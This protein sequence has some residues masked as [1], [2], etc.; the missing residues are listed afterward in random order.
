VAKSNSGGVGL[1]FQATL[2]RANNNLGWVI[3]RLPA[4]ATAKLGGRGQIRVIGNISGSGATSTPFIFRTTLF[5]DGKGGH[6]LLV[7]RT[8]QKGASV[9]L[10]HVAEIHLQ[11]DIEQRKVEMPRE[12]GLALKQD[13][14]LMRWFNE[15]LS[16]SQRQ[17]TARFISQPRSAAARKRRAERLAERFM[18]TMEAEHDL[19][20][21][22]R[23]AL[24]KNYK[25]AEGWKLMSQTQRRAQLL[26]IFYYQTPEA[27]AR[28]L[29]KVLEIAVAR[30]EKQSGTED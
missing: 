4:T 30:Y 21:L 25:A 6:F 9:R 23:V 1:R 19:P 2:E 3:A 15:S 26:G 18:L 27:Q 14:Q 17:D 13:R 24:A 11:R 7:N 16:P 5:P 10:G 28:R 29:A 22:L 20:P 8:M 12:M